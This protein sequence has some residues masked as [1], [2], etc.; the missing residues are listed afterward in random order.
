MIFKV[1]YYDI[2]SF[3][4]H[5]YSNWSFKLAFFC[6]FIPKTPLK[7]DHIIKPSVQ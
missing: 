5:V 4:I 7:I 2:T 1:W 3:I 6:P